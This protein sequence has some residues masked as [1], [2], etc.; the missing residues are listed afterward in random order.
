MR[1]HG[2]QPTHCRWSMV[3]AKNRP[4]ALSGNLRATCGIRRISDAMKIIVAPRNTSSETRR[5]AATAALAA[6]LEVTSAG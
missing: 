3:L 5:D 2:A 4:T 1:S 6:L